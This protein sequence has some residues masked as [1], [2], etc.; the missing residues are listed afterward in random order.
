MILEDS[1]NVFLDQDAPAQLAPLGVGRELLPVVPHGQVEEDL[2]AGRVLDEKAESW[3]EEVRVAFVVWLQEGSHWK[4]EAGGAEKVSVI[5][6]CTGQVHVV[7]TY[8]YMIPSQRHPK[9]VYSG[10]AAA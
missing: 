2:R 4:F 7:F 8:R 1:R 9:A 6:W 10:W 3:T 5:W